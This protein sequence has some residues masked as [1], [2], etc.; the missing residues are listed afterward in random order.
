MAQETDR[1]WTVTAPSETPGKILAAFEMLE[2][3]LEIKLTVS[4]S[5]DLEQVLAA[6]PDLLYRYRSLL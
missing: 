2:K 6:L 1:E 5:Q 3:G 4:G